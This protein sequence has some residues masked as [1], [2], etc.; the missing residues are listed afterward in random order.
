MQVSK[1]VPADV[2]NLFSGIFVLIS[3]VL[4]ERGVEREPRHP[5][6]GCFLPVRVGCQLDYF[7]L[8]RCSD[9]TIPSVP[10]SALTCSYWLTAFAF[11]SCVAV[12]MWL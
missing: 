9:N 2:Q 12:I 4:N 6:C 3:V 11:G 10:L 7:L 5:D 1:G 8:F